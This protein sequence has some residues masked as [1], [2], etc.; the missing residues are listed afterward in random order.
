MDRDVPACLPQPYAGGATEE[1]CN[2]FFP[3]LLVIT[4]TI[5][6]SAL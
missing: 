5:I 2:E 6:I 3:W 1:A 4:S